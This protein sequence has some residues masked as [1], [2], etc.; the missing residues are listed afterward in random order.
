MRARVFQA[1]GAAR[2]KGNNLAHSRVQLTYPEQL[3]MTYSMEGKRTFTGTAKS[4]VICISF[5]LLKNN[6]ET[7][8]NF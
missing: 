1:K 6:K 5:H 7:L 3:G 8:Q 2:V 4:C